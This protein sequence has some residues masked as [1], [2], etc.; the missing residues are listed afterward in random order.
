M[1]SD[2]QFNTPWR[3]VASTIYKKP[4]DSKILGGVEL[5]VT[6]LESFISEK[7]R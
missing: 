7:R 5:D 4:T 3:R 2:E 6:D 1:N